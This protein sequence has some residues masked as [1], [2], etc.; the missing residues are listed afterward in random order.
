[1]SMIMM[2]SENVHPNEHTF[3]MEKWYFEYVKVIARLKLWTNRSIY[4]K[5]PCL[6]IPSRAHFLKPTSNKGHG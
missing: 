5:A 2:L 6:L 3:Q 1:M 4:T